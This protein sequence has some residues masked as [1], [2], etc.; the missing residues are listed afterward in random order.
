M[1]QRLDAA[2]ADMAVTL[3]NWV[4]SEGDVY[5]RHDVWLFTVQPMKR[6][7]AP[8]AQISPCEY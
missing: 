8:V 7:A 1:A 2:T 4:T 3:N 5:C 6:V